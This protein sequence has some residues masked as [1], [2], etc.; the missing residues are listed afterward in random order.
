[1]RDGILGIPSGDCWMC[2]LSAKRGAHEA[3]SAPAMFLKRYDSKRVR[4]WGSVNDMIPWEL[5]DRRQGAGV[6]P[7]KESRE[8]R[9]S[10]WTLFERVKVNSRRAVQSQELVRTGGREES[11]GS[12][13]SLRI[14]ILCRMLNTGKNSRN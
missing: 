3:S 14:S 5:G 2:P 7:A 1:M 11:F 6:R 4:G 13:C 9:G 10:D 12:R 8:R